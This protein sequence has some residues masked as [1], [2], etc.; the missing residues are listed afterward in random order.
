MQRYPKPQYIRE[1]M[2]DVNQPHVRGWK[3][4]YN[5]DDDKF[6]VHE[7]YGEVRAVIAD[8]RNVCQWCRNHKD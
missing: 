3:V 7:L 6:Y 2:L 1:N 5:P 4:S 8:W